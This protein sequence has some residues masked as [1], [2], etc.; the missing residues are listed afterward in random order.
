M[1]AIKWT[2]PEIVYYAPVSAKFVSYLTVRDKKFSLVVQCIQ[3][4]IMQ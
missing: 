1:T 2:S 3:N 4:N